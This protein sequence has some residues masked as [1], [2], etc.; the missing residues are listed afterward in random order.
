LDWPDANGLT[1]IVFDNLEL[2]RS[3]HHKYIDVMVNEKVLPD[4]AQ[5]TCNRKI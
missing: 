2:P 3:G 4:D 1:S 5:G